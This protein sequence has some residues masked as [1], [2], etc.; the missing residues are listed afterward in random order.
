M[1]GILKNLWNPKEPMEFPTN[2]GAPKHRWNLTNKINGNLVNLW[3]PDKQNPQK[4][5]GIPVESKAGPCRG[6]Q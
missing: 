1:D 5:Y 2:Y 6:R 4:I 3:N